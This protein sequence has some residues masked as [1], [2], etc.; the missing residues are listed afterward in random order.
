[1]KTTVNNLS[2]EQMREILDGAPEGEV[3]CHF[4]D[5]EFHYFAK[6]SEYFDE[7]AMIFEDGGWIGVD[8]GYPHNGR[9]DKAPYILINDLRTAI[10]SH[11]EDHEWED[12]RNHVSPNCKV[13]EHNN[14]SE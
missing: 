2:I 4:Y 11:S 6:T 12:T 10:A 8:D 14:E 5:P 13:M 1:M 9:L 7:A 3:Y